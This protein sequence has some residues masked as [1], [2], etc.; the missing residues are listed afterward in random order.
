M[1]NYLKC[2]EEF[3][4]AHPS[5]AGKL[6]IYISDF[7]I[8]RKAVN[9]EIKAKDIYNHCRHTLRLLIPYRVFLGALIYRG[10]TPFTTG[11]EKYLGISSR[12]LILKIWKR[13]PIDMESFDIQELVEWYGGYRGFDNAMF[14]SNLMNVAW[15]DLDA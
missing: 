1:V 6:E 12:S 11:K 7:M 9:R 5:A 8:P 2:F 13:Q 4:D 15:K 3:R 14:V 10:I